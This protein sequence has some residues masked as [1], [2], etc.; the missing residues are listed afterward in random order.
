V[1]E[2]TTVVQALTERGW[3]V[4]AGERFRLRSEPAIRVTISTLLPEDARRFAAD[5][6]A[7]LRSRGRAHA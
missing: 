7:T 1:R 6:S 2:E 4:A 5:L 3:G